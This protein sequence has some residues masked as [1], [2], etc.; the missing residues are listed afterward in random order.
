MK[1]HFEP[2]L[3]YQLHAIEAVCDL[4]RG[5]EICR[6]E[7]TVTRVAGRPDGELLRCGMRQLIGPQ[8]DLGIGNRLTL[9]DDELLQ[10]SQRH[11]APQWSRAVQ[12]A[13]LRRFHGRDGDRHRQDLC[14]PAHHLRAEQALRVHQVRHRRAVDRHQG[15]R[16]QDAPDHR[17]AL[18]G[19]LRRRPF[20]Y[21]L[22]DSTKL[23]QVRNFATSA[24]IQIMVVTVGAINKKDVNNSLQGQREDGR[25]K[26]DRSDQ[27]HAP[28]RDRGRTAERGWRPGRSGGRTALER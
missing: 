23:G 12:Y 7:F 21:F 22:Y 20:D 15:G 17:G 28:D 8:N 10:E 27:G 24:Q 13:H 9:L 19:A 25:R 2:N 26:A 6:T 14:L 5:Q 1:L 11:P 18:Q 3:D 16:L 4:F